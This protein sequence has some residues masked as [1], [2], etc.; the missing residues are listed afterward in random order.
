VAIDF[1]VMPL[2]RYLSGD[3]ITPAM[4]VAWDQGVPYTIVSPDG[5]RE[6]PPGLPFGG[7]DAPALIVDW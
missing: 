7:A 3:F 6:L 1:M 2:S 5:T 4:R